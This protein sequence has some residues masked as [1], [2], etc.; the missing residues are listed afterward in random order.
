MRNVAC[1]LFIQ[2]MIASFGFSIQAAE[3]DSLKNTELKTVDVTATPKRNLK[4]TYLITNT[5]TINRGELLRA[6]CCNLGESFTTNPS[7]D[8]NYNDAATGTRQIKLL[9]LSGIYVQMLTENV[10]NFKGAAIPFALDFVPGFW[11]QSIQISKGASSVKNGYE[12]ITGQIN[13]NYWKPQGIEGVWGNLHLNS[14]LKWEGDV[15]GTTHINDKLSTNLLLHIESSKMEHDRNN[16]QFM[17]A[18]KQRQI[19]AQHRWGWITNRFISQLSIRGTHDKRE[20]GSVHHHHNHD[21]D[22]A[23]DIDLETDRAD[24]FWKNALFTNREKNGSVALILSGSIHN[25]EYH[26]GEKEHQFKQ[27]NAYAQFLFEED[28]TP[29]HNL[30]VGASLNHDK[31]NAQLPYTYDMIDFQRETTPGVYAQYTYKLKEKLSVMAGIRYD[32]SNLYGGFVT[33]RIHLKYAPVNQFSLRASAGKG[34]RSPHV[35]AENTTTLASNR[36]I[37]IDTPQQEEA[38][39]V[40]GSITFSPKIGEKE[41]PINVDYYYTNFL[42]QMVL[43]MSEARTLQIYAL[44][45]GA[46]SYSH[47]AQIDVSRTIKQVSLLA[48]FRWQDV[49]QS[50]GCQKTADGGRDKGRLQERFLTSR[51]KALLT[52]SWN[53]PLDLWKVDLTLQVNGPGKMPTPYL[54]NEQETLNTE[55]QDKEGNRWSWKPDYKAFPQLN[56]Q[57]TREFRHFSVYAGGENLTNFKQKNPIVDANHPESP[58]F[59]ATMVWGPTHGAMAYAG[60]RINFEK[61]IKE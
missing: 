42:H 20:S 5:E 12:S 57:I 40:G 39:N 27:S 21:I 44:P 25:A 11:I 48:A 58:N 2:W 16:D 45:D 7:V 14:H 29:S 50:I 49:K 1:L 31:W 47:T 38:W 3:T 43:D 36:S 32:Y 46:Q 55:Y 60:V 9:G 59:D 4:S 35:L 54:L 41:L 34:Y 10:P 13:V 30:S 24:F 56:L 17:D 8:A 22:S 37:I 52:A 18:P 19:N 6:A 23:Y 15:Y 33:P 51:Y 61:P 26:F 53:D 28:L